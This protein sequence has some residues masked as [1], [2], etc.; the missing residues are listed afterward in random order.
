[1]TGTSLTSLGDNDRDRIPVI[2]PEQNSP[3]TEMAGGLCCA[4]ERN[5]GCFAVVINQ[6]IVI[7]LK[8]RHAT[9]HL[10]AIAAQLSRR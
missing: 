2:P 7:I 5:L 4:S 6:Q 8:G 9:A 10:A 1:M 3:P